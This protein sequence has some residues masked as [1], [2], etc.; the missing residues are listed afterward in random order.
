MQA[1]GHYVLFNK[2]KLRVRYIKTEDYYN[3]VIKNIQSYPQRPVVVELKH[4]HIYDLCN[5]VS[6]ASIII[7]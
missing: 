6:C 7:V 5:D 3:E 1:I 2:S 4:G